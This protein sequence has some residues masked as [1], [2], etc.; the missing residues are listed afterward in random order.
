MKVICLDDEKII[1]QGMIINC[2]KV[3]AITEVIGFNTFKQLTDYLKD[4][5]ADVIFCDINMPA[6]LIKRYSIPAR[7]CVSSVVDDRAVQP[8][9]L[10]AGA[11]LHK[12]YSVA[13][14]FDRLIAV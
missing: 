9:Q 2:K 3:E 6:F 10:A 4:N 14:A 11:L 1:L 13:V 7:D 5:T 8:V 12:F